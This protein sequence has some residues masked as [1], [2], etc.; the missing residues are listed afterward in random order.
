VRL[1]V[2]GAG[3]VYFECAHARSRMDKEEIQ[4]ASSGDP[5]LGPAAREHACAVQGE[6]V[7]VLPGRARDK[8]N[9]SA[10]R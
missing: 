5:R 4:A 3:E 1:G 10:R 9:G 2:T 7:R 8:P 6:C